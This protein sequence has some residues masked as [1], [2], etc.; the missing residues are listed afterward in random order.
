VAAL[1]LAGTAAACS[2]DDDASGGG[3]SAPPIVTEVATTAPVP[4][5]T[6]V[7]PTTSAAPT[8]AAPPPVT[9]AYPGAEWETIDAGTAGLDP[10]ALDRL[11]D[12]A[13]AAGSTC[14]AIIR[15][16]KLVES[17]TWGPFAADAPREAWSVTKSVT[18]TL[19]GI[20]QDQGLLTVA[21]RVSTYV[22]EWVGT[23]S[24]AVTIRDILSNASGR[25]WDVDTDYVRMASGADDKTAFAIALG[26]DAPPGEIW[27]YNNS[28]IQVL[29]AV[30]EAATGESP[31][32]YAQ[33]MLFEPIGMTNSRLTTDAA[34]N[35]LMFAGLQSTCLDLARFGYLMLHDGDWNGTQVVSGEYVA[36]ATRESSTEL[37]AAYGWLWWLNQRGPIGSALLATSGPGDGSVAEGQLLP[38]HSADTFWAL[39]L[40]NQIVAVVPTEDIVAVRM[41][42]DPP[43]DAPF[44]AA[45][46]TGG[47]LDAVVE[48]RPS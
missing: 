26:Q 17:R 31:V 48:H 23:P 22:P 25:H 12:Q 46:L 36:R 34:G 41:G 30:L 39:G 15:D 28:A 13:E 47:V 40:F 27:A 32:T 42:S 44:A 45:E 14:T 18:S 38:D 24:E 2:G 16:G 4:P 35:A 10:A 9:F 19:I 3:S 11:A 5:P 21:D 33:R 37:N 20:A 29:E 8:T 6:F 43:E 7:A 1:L